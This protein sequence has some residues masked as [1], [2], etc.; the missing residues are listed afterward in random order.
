[1]GLS[2]EHIKQRL[3]EKFPEQVK[4]FDVDNTVSPI[5]RSLTTRTR[6]TFI[7]SISFNFR[8]SQGL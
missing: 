5:E 1:M 7:Q 3:T 6:F 8:A 2:N 4:G